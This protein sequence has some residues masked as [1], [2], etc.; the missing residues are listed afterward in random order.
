[1]GLIDFKLDDIGSLARG[2]REA[3]TGEKIKDPVEMAKIQL[4]LE[5]LEAAARS[6]NLKINEVEAAHPNVFI[7]GW[8]PAIGWVAA[9]SLA[10]VYIPKAL[11]ITAM[12]TYKCYL[13]FHYYEPTLVGGVLS[14]LP[15]LP[16]FPEIS[17]ADVLGLVA[18]MLG[19]GALRSYDKKNGSD[20][21]T[22]Q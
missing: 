21:R 11:V 22:I 4:Q 15:E 10:T 3:I 5:G 19:M 16:P 6:G 18:S 8:R 2:V 20:T 14:P 1:M 13:L 17:L 9:V 12:W 7:A